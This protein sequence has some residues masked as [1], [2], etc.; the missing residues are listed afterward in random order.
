M[1]RGALFRANYR[2]WHT[3]SCRNSGGSIAVE[4]SLARL[5]ITEGKE[6]HSLTTT[7]LR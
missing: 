2:G 1:I 6:L 3:D 4:A 7:G 5:E